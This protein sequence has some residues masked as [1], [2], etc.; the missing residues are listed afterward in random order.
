[1]ISI[2]RFY[3]WGGIMEN[4]KMSDEALIKLAY[5]AMDNAYAPYSKF[6]VGAALLTIGG[7]VYTGCNIE[8]ASYGATN[9]AER[10]AVFKAVSD[11]IKEFEAI[12]IVSSSGDLTPPCGICRQVLS[13]FAPNLKIILSS[14]V[15]ENYKSSIKR[16]NIL[17]DISST[18]NIDSKIYYLSE[19]LPLQFSNLDIK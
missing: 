9:C 2:E 8:C 19:L 17:Y 13:E 5:R 7:K 4:N 14:V 1:M 11:G 15:A 16:S 6:K 10:T 12:A 3:R 18:T